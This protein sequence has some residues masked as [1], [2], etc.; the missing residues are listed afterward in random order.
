MPVYDTPLQTN[1]QSLDRLLNA[2][3]P[4][5]LLVW[6]SR[7]GADGGLEATLKQIAR[8]EA[9]NLLVARL[10]A[11]DNPQAEAR[12]G[13]AGT[14]A[15]VLYRDGEAVEDAIRPVTATGLGAY[16]AYL[17][18]RGPRPAQ[19]S[20]ANSAPNGRSRPAAANGHDLTRPVTVTDAT[21]QREVLKCSLP[22]I[23]DFW[24][25]WCGPCRMIGP[26]LER[27]AAELGGRVKIAK[28]NIDENPAWAGQYGVQGIPTLLLVRDGQIVDRIVGALPESYLRQRIGAFV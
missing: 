18:G 5:L 1:D 17:L 16:V 27:I 20:G 26:A 23:V 11:A 4:V 12:W 9:G 2:G 10:D 19:A 13:A 22:V 7:R 21:F 6:D 24:A 15:L 8:A 14:P 25:P 3:L 28:V